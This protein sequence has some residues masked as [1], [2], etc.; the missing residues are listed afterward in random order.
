MLTSRERILRIMERKDVDRNGFWL[1]NPHRDAIKQYL[2]YFDVRSHRQLMLKLNSD[3]IWLPADASARPPVIFRPIGLKKRTSLSQSGVLAGAETVEDIEKIYFPKAAKYY[4]PDMRLRLMFAKRHD[5]AVF[6]GMST[7]FWHNLLDHFGMEECFVKM[8]SHPEV[9]EAVANKVVDIYLRA[10]EAL[11]KKYAEA[12]DAVFFFNDIGTQQDTM[13]SPDLFRQYFMPGAKKLID[14]AKRYKLKV[15]LHSCGSVERFI[16]DFINA[17]V[18][19]LHPI[20][21]KARN[22]EAENLQSKYGKNIVFMGGLDTQDILPFG[23]P[24][25]VRAET[26]RLIDLFGPHF[27]LSPSHEAL[28][29]NVS[30]ANVKA[31]AEEATKIILRT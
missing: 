24:D 22:M 4:F 2:R 8:Y 14:Q 12:I 18:D 21:A 19:V 11:Y 30:G 9:V 3:L 5:L 23:S 20:Q 17:G 28:L 10:N 7:C 15:A 1:G 16:P 13:V 27:I 26:R 25:Q 31:M 29:P 6:S